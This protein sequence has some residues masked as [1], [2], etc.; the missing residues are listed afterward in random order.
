[1]Y[2]YIPCDSKLLLGFQWSI[3]G[4]PNNYLESSR[5]ILLR[6]DPATLS[7]VDKV[8]VVFVEDTD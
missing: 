6:R 5:I 2:C 4:N 3:N 7:K 1:M 8:S